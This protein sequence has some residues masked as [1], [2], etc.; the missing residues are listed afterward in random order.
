MK[1][2]FLSLLACLMM[3][4]FLCGCNS[5]NDVPENSDDSQST[6]QTEQKTAADNVKYW[7]IACRPT[8]GFEQVHFGIDG[9]TSDISI[10]L[11]KEW[12]FVKGANGYTVKRDGENIG[13]II[14]GEASDTAKWKT[15]A[16]SAKTVESQL[17]V[18]KIIERSIEA[19]EPT[20]RYRYVFR[21]SNGE[22]TSVITLTAKYEEVDANAADL[23]GGNAELWGNVKDLANTLEELR[24]KTILILGNSFINSSDIGNILNVMLNDSGKAGYVEAVSY[25][26]YDV[27]K[28]ADNE[29][30]MERIRNG[31]YGAVFMCGFYSGGDS[32]RLS[33]IKSVCDKA[34]TELIIFPAHNESRTII[35]SAIKNNPTLK[36][37][38]WKNEIDNLIAEGVSYDDFCINDAHKHSTALAGYVGAQMIYR[39]IWGEVPTF[40]GSGWLTR[41]QV[42][43]SL[44]E[45]YVREGK[46]VHEYDLLLLK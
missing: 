7:E 33:E 10:S 25:G 22:A 40:N 21:Y 17:I 36:V 28:Y 35:D 34:G 26:Y 43:N 9:E 46:I 24:N 14:K 27:Q 38:D 19:S 44:G 45:D 8:K 15:A 16:I 3:A 37:F 11:P 6:A 32:T 31:G 30:I 23:I 41:E 42:V 4:A 39:A 1:K 29:S 20:F 13:E 18:D 12:E 5:D 2:L